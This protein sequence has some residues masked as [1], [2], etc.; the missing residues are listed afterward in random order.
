MSVLNPSKAELWERM[1][2]YVA[3][4][5]PTLTLTPDSDL[6]IVVSML[7]EAQYGVHSQAAAAYRDLFVSAQTSTEALDKH[8]EA[9]LGGRKGAVRA[10]GT[11]AL[12]VTG[13][14]GSIVSS[15]DELVASDGTAYVL[16]SG[17]TVADGTLDVSL[18]AVQG[19]AAGN[20]T[21]GETLTFLQSPA[22]VASE[23]VLMNDVGGGLDGES[24]A[25]LVIR[26]LDAYGNPP[27]GG[28]FSDWR[29]WATA[30][31]GVASAYCYGPSSD[32]PLG[33]RGL[34]AVDVAILGS[35]SGSARIPSA[36]VQAAVEDAIAAQRPALA[37]DY[38][39]L[40]P[41]AIEQNVQVLLTPHVG[42]EFDWALTAPLAV[43][44]YAPSTRI[45]T[46]SRVLAAAE[47]LV[48]NRL[49][50]A[51]QLFTVQA[52]GASTITLADTP[53]DNPAP[54][55]AVYIA[56]PLTAPGMAA[57]LALFDTLG[58]A[59]GTAADPDQRWDDSLLVASIIDVLMDL[60]GVA[61]V[62]VVT[63]ASDVAPEDAGGIVQ[64]LVPG[65]ITVSGYSS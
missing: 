53:A 43:S 45:V 10:A 15:G 46:M 5:V 37:R 1:R 18:E 52:R 36:T 20:R 64:L 50:I 62:E 2:A 17:G 8:A 49:V 27:A 7:I 55:D 6:G 11:L 25:D 4:R 16:T 63:P 13:E 57:I 14:D 54:A 40:L 48:G 35:G 60:P 61:N 42:W 47:L 65:I 31:E 51:G 9:R 23:A 41:Q 3:S 59:R 21:T 38:S 32:V 19:G 28:R 24:D 29:Q 33:R 30:I 22:G 12:T 56:G 39:V 34:G 44:S 58:P 26:L